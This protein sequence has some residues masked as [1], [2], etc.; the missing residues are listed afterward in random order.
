MTQNESIVEE[1]IQ[2]TRAKR[3]IS[4]KQKLALQRAREAKAAKA[5]TKAQPVTEAKLTTAEVESITT[6]IEAKLTS[7]EKSNFFLPKREI[8]LISGGTLLMGLTYWL[9]FGKSKQ[10][11]PVKEESQPTKQSSQPLMKSGIVLDF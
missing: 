2:I 11:E 5:I 3:E 1:P 4:D 8:L 10:S 6:P 7:G 9:T